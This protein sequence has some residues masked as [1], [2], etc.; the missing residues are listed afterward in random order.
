MRKSAKQV[1]RLIYISL[2]LFFVGLCISMLNT[3][4]TVGIAAIVPICLCGIFYLYI[5]TTHIKDLQSPYKTLFTRPIF[6]LIQTYQQLFDDRKWRPLKKFEVY[7]EEL[8]M[9]EKE[10]KKRDVSAVRW[11]VDN[12]AATGE[13]E[14]LVLAIPGTFN[15]EWGRDVWRDVS[16][17]G[18]SELDTLDTPID[19][20]APGDSSPPILPFPLPTERP[21]EGTAVDTICRCVRN[22]FV[23]CRN[24]SYFE[25]EEARRRRMHACVEAAAS[26]VCCIGFRVEWLGDVGKLVSEIGKIEQVNLSPTTT[27]DPSFVVRWTCLSLVSVQQILGTDRLQVL[28][29]YAVSGLARFQSEY[30]RVD[31]TSWRSANRIE[32]RLK[33]AWTLVEELRQSFE[34]WTEK[35]TKEQ[36]KEILRNHE[37]QISELEHIKVEAGSMEDVDWRISLYQ[38]AMDD[39]THGLAR[40]LPGVSF[41]EPRRSESSL[42]RDTFNAQTTGSTTVTP[43]LIFPGQ[44]VQAL[45]RLGSKLREV[46]D[47]QVADGH[48]EV[49]D[50]LKSVEQVPVSLRRPNGLMKQ[51]LL[52]L[53]DLRD[54][55]GLGFTIELF[56]L[57]LRQLLTIPSLHESNSALYI[58]TFKIITSRWE[59][60]KDSFG[61]QCILLNIVCDLTIRGRG[62]FSDFSYPEPITTTLLEMVSKILGGFSGSDEHIHDAVWEIESVDSLGCRD[63]RLRKSALEALQ[64]FRVTSPPP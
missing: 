45:A 48:E 38:E 9:D 57:S 28:A 4:T 62:V 2:I 12:T 7:Q 27:S 33:A 61:T 34:P 14:P 16:S 35:K 1:P 50:S 3:N 36:V 22:L 51:Q 26:L 59:E 64:R 47:G 54:G 49:L 60:S 15:T 40:L 39:A 43:Q 30:G 17:Q 29:A 58:G 31:E 42:I 23:T 63:M 46:L 19:Q 37:Q 44:R 41:D 25:S 18:P 55:G 21:R 53:Q 20:S 6:F 11:L 24:H 56:F 8:V 5:V 32:D 10:R 13:I 52:R